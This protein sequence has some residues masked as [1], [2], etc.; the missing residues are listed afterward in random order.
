MI[1]KLKDLIY[2]IKHMNILKADVTIAEKNI[3][4]ADEMKIEMI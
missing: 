3:D 4:F 1:K 2:N